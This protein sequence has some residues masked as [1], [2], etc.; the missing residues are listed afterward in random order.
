M[1]NCVMQ[2]EIE[3]ALEEIRNPI[4]VLLLSS[5]ALKVALLAIPN[6]Q[7][8]ENL[9]QEIGDFRAR[10]PYRDSAPEVVFDDYDHHLMRLMRISL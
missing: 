8:L 7:A 6:Q 10:L 2:R 3:I 4:D 9:A 1:V 5:A